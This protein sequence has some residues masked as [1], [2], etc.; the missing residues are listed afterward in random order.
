M[1]AIRMGSDGYVDDVA[2]HGDVFRMEQLDSNTIWVCIYR[3]EDRTSFI[4]RG[5]KL[6]IVVQ[7]DYLHCIDDSK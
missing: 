5:K 3:G 2:I 1:E 7:D 6:H 4:V